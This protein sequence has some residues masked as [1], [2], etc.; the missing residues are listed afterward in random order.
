MGGLDY[1]TV[2][3]VTLDLVDG[4]EPEDCVVQAMPDVSPPKWHLAHTTWFF[5]TFV[6]EPRG[7][8]YRAFNPAFRELFNSYYEAVGPRHP[9]PARG[10]LSRPTVR[11]VVR[12]REHVDAAMQR[13]FERGAMD[14]RT[15]A[16]VEL[17]LHHEQQHQ[18]LL[19]MDVKFNFGESPLQPAHRPRALEPCP[20]AP[21]SFKAFEGGVVRIGHVGAGFA[22]DN[23]GPAHRRFLEPF[24]LA[25]RLVTN[26][27]WL[28]FI[29]A[30]GY[31]TASLWLS[32]GWSWVNERSIEQPLYWRR[33][34][35]GEWLELT[36]HG[37]F[38]LD[39]NAPVCH[40]SA[41][42]AAAFAEWAGARLPTEAEWEHAAQGIDPSAARALEDGTWHPRAHGFLGEVW[43][44]TR[45]AYE[46]YPGFRP[47]PGAVGEYNGKFMSSQWVL[48][49]SA[50]ITP[51]GHAR[52][53]YRNFFYPHQRW[54]M[55]GLRL[56]KSA[57]A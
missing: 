49:G 30:G 44:W 25:S 39:P 35:Q 1:S 20:A 28:E 26:G 8:D 54:P 37:A 48:R 42:E 18:E 4:L 5:E 51:R 36:C 38:P 16:L 56:A 7:G 6:L 55:T 22:F 15:L 43:Q 23:E 17:G 47:A 33:S 52:A 10:H 31:R 40:V 41:Y 21:L 27:E 50:A 12:Y 13:L 3:R 29:R 24:E 11:E 19:V 14:E 9:R 53:S 57:T 45:S 34:S 32:D 46:P 2:R